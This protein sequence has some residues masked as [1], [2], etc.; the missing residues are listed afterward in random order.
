M[1]ADLLLPPLA[2]SLYAHFLRW[3]RPAS[4]PPRMTCIA[5]QMVYLHQR[6]VTYANLGFPQVCPIAVTFLLYTQTLMTS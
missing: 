1:P 4:I 6:S 5:S 3:L 2:F